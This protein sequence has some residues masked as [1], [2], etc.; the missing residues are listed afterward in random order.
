MAELACGERI[1]R[2]FLGEEIDRVPFNGRLCWAPWEE[3]LE[4]WRTETGRPDLD[5]GVSLVLIWGSW[6]LL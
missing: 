3:T 1:V 5:T 2:C 6:R 4:R